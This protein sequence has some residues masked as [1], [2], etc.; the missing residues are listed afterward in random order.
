MS[1]TLTPAIWAIVGL[2]ALFLVLAVI[3][4][5]RSERI[6]AHKITVIAMLS[7]VYV[8]LNQV[9]TLRFGWINVSSAP[10][11]IVIAA[12][13][14]GPFAGLMVG[15]LGSFLGQLMTFGLMVTTVLWI[16][17]PAM[18]GLL[19]GLWAKRRG[20]RLSFWEMCAALVLTSLA[21]TVLNTYFIYL[22]SIIF[23]YYTEVLM[24]GKFAIRILNSVVTSIAL[25]LVAPP[26]VTL[27]RNTLHE[28]QE[29]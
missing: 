22:D 13:L 6:T 12:L 10:L 20:Y 4:T 11:P 9:G 8:V 26:V 14:Y 19:L 27:L 25:L 23:G 17:P 21:V 24:A 18:R 28:T 5:A 1:A 29:K 2:T 3:L 7:A 15:L 16:A